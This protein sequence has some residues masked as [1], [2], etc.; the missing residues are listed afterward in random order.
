MFGTE[1][2]WVA[3]TGTG[4]LGSAWGLLAAEEGDP[5]QCLSELRQVYGLGKYSTHSDGEQRGCR[6]GRAPTEASW[7]PRQG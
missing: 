7:V 3:D 4:L 6:P 1:H 2:N 5:Y